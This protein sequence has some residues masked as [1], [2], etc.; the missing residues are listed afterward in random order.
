MTS[1]AP[2]HRQPSTS[3]DGS[4][5]ILIIDD[6]PVCRSWL[7]GIIECH[8]FKA[9]LADDGASGLEQAQTLQPAAIVL[10]VR[11]PGLGGIEV[12]RLLRSNQRTA[13]VPILFL[14][15][16]S[17]MSTRIE[18]FGIPACHFANKPI[19]ANEVVARLRTLLVDV[20]M[21]DFEAVRRQAREKE[22]RLSGTQS[23]L[24]QIDIMRNLR[25]VAE[26]WGHRVEPEISRAGRYAGC[27]A[28]ACGLGEEE[29]ELLKHAVALRDIGI[30]GIPDTVLLKQSDLTERERLEVQTHSAIGNMI[31]STSPASTLMLM[32]AEVAMGHHERWDGTGYPGN[33]QGQRIPRSARIAAVADVLEALTTERPYRAAWPLD[34]AI[35]EITAQ[36]GRQFDPAVVDAFLS[37]LPGIRAIAEG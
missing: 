14:T 36:C 30:V 3:I 24:T 20:Q 8:G 19:D 10:D 12:S 37:V 6:D 26:L 25:R 7:A 23:R 27:I 34:R 15:A 31:L 29:A 11:M 22:A 35:A 4:K 5:T 13:A 18:A 9:I 33:L 28:R 1:A 2:A 17:D 32:A 16:A 21:Q